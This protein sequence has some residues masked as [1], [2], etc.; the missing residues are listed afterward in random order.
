M[1]S[2]SQ[3]T[4][5]FRVRAWRGFSSTPALPWP[6]KPE[7]PGTRTNTRSGYDHNRHRNAA[8]AHRGGAGGGARDPEGV[9]TPAALRPHRARARD[10]TAGQ[11]RPGQ[12]PAQE[13]C[14]I[15]TKLALSETNG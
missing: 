10:G 6:V 11:R 14:D 2:S 12:I 5:C 13:S 15:L 4:M 9:S 3:T 1:R 7:T 8:E